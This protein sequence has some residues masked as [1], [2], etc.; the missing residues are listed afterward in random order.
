[1]ELYEFC[2]YGFFAAIIA[3]LFFPLEDPLVGLIASYGVFA[4]GFLSRPLG[5]LV[6]GY[7]GDHYGRQRAL[8]L[9]IAAM[10][11]PTLAMGLLPTYAQI[12]LAAPVLLILLRMAQGF[13]LGGELMGS[14]AFLTEATPRAHW[15]YSASWSIVGTFFGQVLALLTLRATTWLTSEEALVSW[16]WRIPFV[17]G[18]L[19]GLLGLLLRRAVPASPPTTAPVQVRSELRRC[20]PSMA[21]LY[22]LGIVTT[23]GFYLIGVYIPVYLC[24]QRKLPYSIAATSTIINLVCT[25][26]ALPPLAALSDRIGRRPVMLV[27]SVLLAASAYPCFWVLLYAPLPLM[28]LAHTFLGLVA[29]VIYAPTPAVF[30]ELFPPSIRHMA[31]SIAYNGAVLSFGGCSPMIVTA[32]IRETGDPLAPAYW[33]IAACGASLLTIALMPE[34]SELVYEDEAL[35]VGTRI[36]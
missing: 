18:A 3:K 7:I 34:S 12:G 15:G 33:L 16:A 22:G 2:L 1:M 13:S 28:M 9:S 25:G 19:F 26:A 10:L 35:L 20:L 23:V 21:Y 32:L 29:A 14:H 4:T 11:L 30:M 27:G 31:S 8:E 24:S 17:L 6:I 36:T 5:G